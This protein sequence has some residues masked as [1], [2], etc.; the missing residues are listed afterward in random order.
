MLLARPSSSLAAQ[1]LERLGLSK[2]VVCRGVIA[3]GASGGPGR[4]S[5]GRVV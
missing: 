3:L 5:P 1:L 4:Q 2:S